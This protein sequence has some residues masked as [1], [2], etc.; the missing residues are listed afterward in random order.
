MNIKR[1]LLQLLFL[2]I[3]V[4]E[5]FGFEGFVGI[6]Q[7]V[8]IRARTVV[9][10]ALL[11]EGRILPVSSGVLVDNRGY[12][13]TTASSL[14]R[15]REIVVTLWDEKRLKA[16]VVGI[17]NDTNLALLKIASDGPFPIVSIKRS[18]TLPLGS[19][20]FMLGN[21][22]GKGHMVARGLVSYQV[23]MPAELENIEMF[24]TDT[25]YLPALRGAAVFDEN[26]ELVGIVTDSFEP[27]S[28]SN[29]V[30]ISWHEIQKALPELRTGQSGKRPRLGVSLRRLSPE[31]AL[32]MGLPFNHGLEV[33]NVKEGS[34]AEVGGLKKGDIIL[35]MD[36]TLIS[37]I[38]DLKE[39]L[40][41]VKADVS[42]DI[43]VYREGSILTL[44]LVPQSE[45]GFSQ[46]PKNII[47]K[48]LGA[49]V[50]LLSPEISGLVGLGPIQALLIKKVIPGSLAD[51]FSMKEGD[52][53]IEVNS[54]PI[55]SITEF[56][57]LLSGLTEEDSVLLKVKRK[58]GYAYI[59][60]GFRH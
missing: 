46:S 43:R 20:V 59:G 48:S 18:G 57:N 55:E 19:E 58:S 47:E 42:V 17:D 27:L 1:L 60:I 3:I 29:G 33:I 53:I 38:A 34:P 11:K 8:K 12:V 22:F 24:I 56:A 39:V 25:N 16:Q 4:T 52:V 40:D 44:S 49:D 13:I 7:A 30:F 54:R 14:E 6:P 9:N 35:Q 45:G 15:D 31:E 50:M 51:R 36:N 10:V 37:D 28:F 5:S 21:P 2:F 26:V 41:R 23:F 32:Q